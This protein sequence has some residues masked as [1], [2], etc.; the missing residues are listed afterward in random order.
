MMKS[1][2][3]FGRVHNELSRLYSNVSDKPSRSSQQIDTPQTSTSLRKRWSV[4]EARWSSTGSLKP[5]KGSETFTSYI[6]EDKKSESDNDSVKYA[7]SDDSSISYR[8]TETSSE[9]HSAPAIGVSKQMFTFEEQ[10]D[11]MP[12]SELLREAIYVNDRVLHVEQ[13]NVDNNQDF[14]PTYSYPIP[15][16]ERGD[17]DDYI[18]LRTAYDIEKSDDYVPMD[19]GNLPLLKQPE[20]VTNKGGIN[21]PVQKTTLMPKSPFRQGDADSI[22]QQENSNDIE[23]DDEHDYSHPSSW[24]P[25]YNNV[26]CKKM[27]K[28]LHEKSAEPKQFKIKEIT[29]SNKTNLGNVT[30]EAIHF[31]VEEVIKHVDTSKEESDYDVP[32][33]GRR[34]VNKPIEPIEYTGDYDIPRA[35][36]PD[37]KN[38]P[39]SDYDV[40]KP[41]SPENDYDI[42]KPHRKLSDIDN[43]TISDAVKTPIYSVKSS[44]ECNAKISKSVPSNQP[45][46]VSQRFTLQN[47]QKTATQSP[48]TLRSVHGMTER[49]TD[50]VSPK[51]TK[52][53]KHFSEFTVDE[54]VD[55]LNK[56]SLVNLA[57]LCD[58]KRIDGA[59]LCNLTEAELIKEPFAMNWFHISKLFK[60]IKGWRPKKLC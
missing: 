32:V 59:C 46:D 26:P 30:K 35:F 15:K 19:Q 44:M 41:Y 49:L 42:P 16:C 9:P 57:K 5:R 20:N 33:P 27:E 25:D 23:S 47:N 28:E 54:V 60:V 34:P 8:D 55:C 21:K 14:E 29:N 53:G 24:M 1:M 31:K 39:E 2:A 40:P 58:D 3:G 51:S 45:R 38:S 6:L 11:S 22:N 10:G 43:A 18:N 36:R 48:S 17:I 56:C 50:D 12:H 4:R 13:Q 37:I 52:G 7:S